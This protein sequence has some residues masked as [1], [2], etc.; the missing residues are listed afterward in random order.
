MGLGVAALNTSQKNE[1]VPGPPFALTSADNG[2]SVDPGTGH[3]VL[4]NAFGEPGSPA[5]L[6]NNREIDLV[7]NVFQFVNG[8]GFRK[9][10]V[11]AFNDT[12]VFGDVD[13]QTG[14]SR[15]ILD[16][17]AFHVQL[18][19]G[20]TNILNGQL[21]AGVNP[22]VTIGDNPATG[23][24]TYLQVDDTNSVVV[25]FLGAN[26]AMQ[27]DKF[28]GFSTVLLGDINAVGNQTGLAVDDFL[29]VVKVNALNGIKV[30]GCNFLI[31]SV[32]PYANGA[33]ALVG[34]LNNSPVA[35]DPTKW[36]RIIDNG[37]TRHIPAW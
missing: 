3:V 13:L 37:I 10:L 30:D 32:T 19:I 1:S 14:G 26:E 28:S 15:I 2:V 22:I 29:R 23:N 8:A 9:L 27:I 4:G 16:P 31:E 20:N 5:Q 25:V 17:A 34:T 11:D 6:L 18:D 12:Y 33:G 24:G 21:V 36:I 7:G 35:G